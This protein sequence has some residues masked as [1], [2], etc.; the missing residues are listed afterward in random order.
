MKE[1]SFHTKTTWIKA[2]LPEFKNQK[3]HKKTMKKIPVEHTALNNK[4]KE[5]IKIFLENLPKIPKGLFDMKVFSS[6]S[7]DPIE[8]R[9]CKC[10]GCLLGWGTTFSKF[11]KEFNNALEKSRGPGFDYLRFYYEIFFDGKAGDTFLFDF[12]FHEYW[13]SDLNCSKKRLKYV[14][15]FGYPSVYL[16]VLEQELAKDFG[17]Q[18]G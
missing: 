2:S 7:G 14:L 1:S 9:D 15:N 12:L 10:S 16:G 11:E 18:K 8:L 5:A 13:A 3:P 17:L 4:Q 6:A